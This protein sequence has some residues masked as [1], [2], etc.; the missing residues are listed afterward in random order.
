M[1][2][3][4]R[5]SARRARS[6]QQVDLSLTHDREVPRSRG[7]QPGS[8]EHAEVPPAIQDNT[9]GD[10]GQIDLSYTSERQRAEQQGDVG[11]END[12]SASGA[13]DGM[14]IGHID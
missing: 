6:T 7:S 14:Q 10:T 9:A 3:T 5:T 12:E 1:E 4:L 2:M 13:R 11:I 8:E